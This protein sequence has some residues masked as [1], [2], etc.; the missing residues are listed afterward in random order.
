VGNEEAISMKATVNNNIITITSTENVS[1]NSM[2]MRI[3]EY[4]ESPYDDIRGKYFHHMY[5]IERY[6][7]ERKKKTFNYF[8]DW[9][10]F[11]VPGNIV[12]NFFKE[13]KHST[14]SD[15]EKWLKNKLKPFL[16]SDKKFY[17]I[18]CVETDIEAMEHEIAH[19]MYYLSPSYRKS[20]KALINCLDDNVR[21]ILINKFIDDGYTKSVFDDEMQAYLATSSQEYF[22][23]RFDDDIPKKVSKVFAD[24]F[25]NF[26]EKFYGY[27]I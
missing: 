19:A 18:G 2:F 4:Y 11:N 5:F 12:K 13:F 17:L 9:S 14:L 1:L 15:R 3:Q 20:C 27:R 25:N 7:I 22:K 6:C 10:G 23:S 24:N 26:K 21:D 16:K 8:A